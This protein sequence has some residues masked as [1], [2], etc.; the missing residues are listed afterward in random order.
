[1]LKSESYRKGIVL[2]TGL[3]IFVKGVLFFNT[4][5]I[6]WYFGTSIDTDLYF[7]IFSTITLISALVN[8][9]DLAVILPEGMHIQEE[10]GMKEA[11]AFYNFFGF[12]YLLIGLLI[13][14]IL[15][16]FSVPF[17]SNVSAFKPGILSSH[18]SL[19]MLSS[20]LPLLI[21]LT[22]YFT[23]VLT[24][25]KFFTAPLIANGIAQLFALVSLFLFH[26]KW[27]VGSILI[28]MLF[29]YLLN[30]SLL[31]FFMYFK[32]QWHVGFSAKHITKRIKTNLASVQL[33]NMATFSFNYGI[34]VV[35]SSLP[36][37]VYSA[38][39][40]SMQILNIPNSFIVGQA[41]AVA[42]IKFNELAA[43]NLPQEFNRIFLQ[44]V[45]ILLFLIIPFCCLSYLYADIIVKFLYLR[46]GF[47]KES[48]EKVVYFMQY[49]IFL[50]PC[51]TINTL[52]TRVMTAGKKVS[53][54]FFFQLSFNLSA[55]LLMIFF[56]RAFM[57][58]GFIISMLVAYYFYV[59]VVCIFLFKWLMPFI[60]Y[61]SVIKTM[62]LIFL[63]NL[64]VMWIFSLIFDRQQPIPLFFIISIGYY[65]I[66]LIVN[67]VFKINKLTDDYFSHFAGKLLPKIKK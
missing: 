40:Y 59:T 48:A 27:G 35:L 19:L 67:H 54:T 5:V 23:S 13:F 37:G 55:L 46:G 43:K 44:S 24:T 47:T 14:F 16:F 22:N 39:N 1:M 10:K 12:C 61:T 34:I 65:A 41:A 20:V 52:I 56:T 32:L 28:G 4:I 62:G 25:L 42:G 21:I 29:G 3:N 6:A 11:M 60:N 7:Y 36:V 17:Y 15:F 50:A 8:G 2:S 38:Y 64:P 45:E 9:M 51:F 58:K 63:F 30:I 53:Q 57:E 49:L 18:S 31:L 66:V 33:G 26:D